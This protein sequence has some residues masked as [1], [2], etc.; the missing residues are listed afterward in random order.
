MTDS[1]L[2]PP[3]RILL[4]D[5]DAGD[6][7]LATRLLEEEL[8]VEVM[9]VADGVAFAWHLTRG[10]F[11]AVICEVGVSWG[12]VGEALEV[13]R[14]HRPEAPFVVFT[15]RADLPALERVLGHRVDALVPKDSAGYLRLPATLGR[16]LEGGTAG[17]PDPPESA[18]SPAEPER[19]REI[20][21]GLSHDLQ[22][23]LQL[24]RR[25]ATLLQELE[26]ERDE[27][28]Q[29]RRYLEHVVGGAE[30]MQNMIDGMLEYARLESGGEPRELVELSEAVETA[31][32]NLRG[33]IDASGAEVRLERLPAVPGDFQQ[34][35]ALFQNLI[36]NAIKFRRE[37]APVVHVGKEEERD[38]WV[39]LVEDR[40]IGIPPEDRERIFALFR[41]LHPEGTY[42]GSGMGLAICRRIVE[43]HGG[44]IWV[45]SAPD[46]GSTFHVRL[47]KAPTPEDGERRSREE[48]RHVRQ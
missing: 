5:D 14:H 27:T 10:D 16:L 23:P 40:G 9:Q 7:A 25:Y 15:A 44:R 46:E 32:A 19:L 24:V 38:S 21:A 37:D 11:D 34:L 26:Q 4:L 30:R 31:L 8:D 41:R 43:R 45:T 48:P 2:R 13:V 18:A 3:R 28:W 17:R 12:E 20:M 29:G 22:E 42:P 36:G 35:V 6:R 33:A 47:P 1:T 39:V